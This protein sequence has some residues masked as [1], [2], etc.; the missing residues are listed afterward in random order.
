META[1]RK[2]LTAPSVFDCSKIYCR[3]CLEA[4]AVI[5]AEHRVKALKDFHTED[6]QDFLQR[7]VLCTE[8]FHEN[9]P[10]VFY[11][12]Q[13]QLCLCQLCVFVTQKLHFEHDVVPL[14]EAAEEKKTLLFTNISR[15][16]RKKQNLDEGVQKMD[17]IIREID[18]NVES[19]KAEVQQLA[20][21]LIANIF[22]HC[23]ASLAQLESVRAS[24]KEIA[25][26]K[27]SKIREESEQ[28]E[29]AIKFGRTLIDSRRTTELL[30]KKEMN[31]H[32]EDLLNTERDINEEA[33]LNTLVKFV[34]EN[35]NSIYRN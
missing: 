18:E 24:R 9:Q 21:L 2:Q 32:F 33:R 25:N 3:S 23:E 1:R 20:N 16:N 5:K 14:E 13:C 30:R 22:K 27:K 15:L 35:E 4:Q 11:C 29:D 19:A 31:K 7:P 26:H 10:L 6:Y 34:A 28:L 17:K 12:K 8:K